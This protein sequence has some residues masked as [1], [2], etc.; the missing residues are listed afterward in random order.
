[1]IVPYADARFYRGIPASRLKA[2][3]QD[4]RIDNSE[5]KYIDE[6]LAESLNRQDY[7]Y[8][9]VCNS[10]LVLT[11]T[12]YLEIRAELVRAL[13]ESLERPSFAQLDSA[14][15]QIFDHTVGTVLYANLSLT[16]YEASKPEVWNYLS[17]RVLPDLAFARWASGPERNVN[18]DRLLGGDRNAFRR[19]HHRL[20]VVD[21]RPDFLENFQEDNLTAVFERTSLIRDY[22]VAQAVL[23]TIAK[24]ILA[25]KP[26]F[27]EARVRDFVSRVMRLGAVQSLEAIHAEELTSIFEGLAAETMEISDSMFKPNKKA[28]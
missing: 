14:D 3:M 2:E 7:L 10:N 25:V 19:L 21:G 23:G 26:K 20:V 8:D 15:R 27:L 24:D 22:D 16:L 1:M 5:S 11:A 4:F 6:Y 13:Q 12:E 18:L 17:A 9:P 28:T